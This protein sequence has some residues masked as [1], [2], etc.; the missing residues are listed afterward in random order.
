[1]PSL[2]K[3]SSR[4]RWWI[5][6][7]IVAGAFALGGLE[8]AGAIGGRGRGSNHAAQWIWLAGDWRMPRPVAF[9]AAADFSLE[10]VPEQASLVVVGD[11]EYVAT[12]NG[13]QVGSGRYHQGSP[14]GR[15]DLEALLRPGGNR[16][17]VELRAAHGGGG[18]LAWVEADGERLVPTGPSW[19]LFR[20]FEGGIVEGWRPLTEG[21]APTLLGPPPIARWR[22][23]A[24]P[25][26][27]AASLVT[28]ATPQPV[29]AARGRSLKPP[30]D[31]QAA[32]PEGSFS[33]TLWSAT[34]LEWS[35]EVEGYLEISFLDGDGGE[36]MLFLAAAGASPDPRFPAAT[37]IARA[38][39][40]TVWR[41]AVARRF[42]RVLIAAKGR[43][44]AAAVWKARADPAADRPGPRA[45][46]LGIEP[47]PLRSPVEDKLRRE[48]EGFADLAEREAG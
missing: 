43:P 31:W 28:P 32:W 12:V 9:L 33:P 25:A 23:V 35:E 8:R 29:P 38:P 27:A 45:G 11:E 6:A 37:L 15:H 47:P 16:V 7:A 24:F 39:G 36:G 19:R 44:I 4:R 34:L 48:F 14:G 40:Q 18:F 2:S 20:A 26:A 3:E 41:D 5:V 30:S 17:V 10:Q 22:D 21:E 42:A 13:W 46:I 1:M